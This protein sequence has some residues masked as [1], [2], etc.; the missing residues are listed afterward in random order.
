MGQ[1]CSPQGVAAR[2]DQHPIDTKLEAHPITPTAV[3]EQQQT[4]ED[5]SGRGAL[6]A[7]QAAATVRHSEKMV[8]VTTLTSVVLYNRLPP[9]RPSIH[10]EALM[11][12]LPVLSTKKPAGTESAADPALVGRPPEAP[13]GSKEERRL[14]TRRRCTGCPISWRAAFSGNTGSLRPCVV[15]VAT[16]ASS[17]A[18]HPPPISPGSPAQA[19]RDLAPMV[20]AERGRLPTSAVARPACL[21]RPAIRPSNS[22]SS[23]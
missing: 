2:L 17:H 16:Q 21:P 20:G 23:G 4:Y 18:A 11:R 9:G 19:L 22:D 14:R 5:N 3:E 10:F 1:C 13:G 15:G 6:D 12:T 8:S 7:F